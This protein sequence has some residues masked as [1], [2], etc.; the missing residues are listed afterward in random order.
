MGA[1]F[2]EIREKCQLPV[3][4]GNDVAG[5]LFGDWMSL[6]I[7]KVFIDLKLSPDLASWLFLLCGL[8]GA[9][10]QLPGAP[11]WP[12]LGALALLLYYVFDCVDGEV[13]RWQGVEDLRWGW[14]D[15]I[16]HMLVKP[17]SFFAVGLGLWMS[18]GA[19]WP[20]IAGAV[21]AIAVLW[22]KLFLEIP[23]I[24]FL[25][26]ALAGGPG[27][28]RAFRRRLA[29]LGAALPAEPASGAPAPAADP[30]MRVQFDLVTLRALLTNYDV[31]LVFLLAACLYDL[32]DAPA[33]RWPWGEVPVRGLW[34]AFY[35]FVLP[36][37]FF[38]Y[39]WTWLRKGRFDA[40]T[41][42]LLVLAHHW[43]AEAPENAPGGMP[44]AAP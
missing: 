20:L 40:E 3:R 41:R 27:G 39:A 30:P 28:T 22:L 25:R 16:F 35:A 44:G 4:H 5:L 43:R 9:A 14:F 36:L 34:L 26:G 37:N 38:D 7:T 2:R 42:R 29:A 32:S 13:A 18:T 8:A 23:G 17:L 31:S 19:V 24:L 33:A 10:L 12:A 6:P 15:Y 21:A 1:S 11:L